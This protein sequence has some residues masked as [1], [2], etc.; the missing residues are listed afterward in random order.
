MKEEQIHFLRFIKLLESVLTTLVLG[1]KLIMSNKSAHQGK[2]N[3]DA[4][5]IQLEI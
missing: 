5:D 2:F 3:S 4:K 1:F